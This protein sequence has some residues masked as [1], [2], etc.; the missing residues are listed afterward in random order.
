VLS[1]I[2]GGYGDAWRTLTGRDYPT[3]NFQLNFSYARRQR[4]RCLWLARAAQLTAAQL[5]A[6]NS[7]S[8]PT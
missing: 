1:T 6:P 2:P 8:P 4:R 3:W 7:R 5:K